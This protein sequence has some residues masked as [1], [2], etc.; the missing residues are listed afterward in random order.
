MCVDRAFRGAQVGTATRLLGTLLAWAERHAVRELFLGTTAQFL[1]AHR[2][3]EKHGFAEIDQSALPPAFPIMR[4]DTKFF[5]RAV[6]LKIT[7]GGLDNPRVQ[8]LLA[9]HFHIARAQTAAGSAH[10]LDLGELQSPAIRF[11]TAWD[12]DRVV[13]VG[14]LKRLSHSHGEI[15]SMHTADSHR[16]RGVASAMLRHIIAVARRMGLSRLS[17]ET[18]SWPYFDPACELYKRHGFLECAPF[19]DY[20]PDP[21]SV[22]M[23]LALGGDA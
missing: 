4:V 8:A 11:W 9:H 6:G 5:H 19:G 12:G 13:G 21:N 23:T 14:A 18:G 2:F 15:K 22:F 3:Y 1:A 20:V 7:D 17:L 10:A 16:R